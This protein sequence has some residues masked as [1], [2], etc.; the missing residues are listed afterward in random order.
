MAVKTK[1]YLGMPGVRY[2]QDSELAL[3]TILRVTRSGIDYYRGVINPVNLQYVYHVGPGK[4]TF[5]NDFNGPPPD[6]P[7][8]LS[9]LEPISVKFKY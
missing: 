4:I 8:T 2:I 7:V 5:E 1:Y 9:Q 6:L 3:V